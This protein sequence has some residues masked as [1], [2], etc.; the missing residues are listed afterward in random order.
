MKYYGFLFIVS[1]LWTGH[2]T[3]LAQAGEVDVAGAVA[4][5]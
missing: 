3:V 5:H 4:G 1:L 2:L